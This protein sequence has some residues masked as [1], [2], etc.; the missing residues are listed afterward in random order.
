METIV[1]RKIPRLHH[2]TDNVICFIASLPLP[3][4]RGPFMDCCS[5]AINPQ[6]I[7]WQHIQTMINTRRKIEDDPNSLGRM[8]VTS[9]CCSKATTLKPKLR[10]SKRFRFNVQMSGIGNIGR[11]ML[12]NP[13]PPSFA[14][15]LPFPMKG[16]SSMR[17][18]GRPG[19]TWDC[20]NPYHAP[21]SAVTGCR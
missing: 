20:L 21:V 13:M 2:Y 1:N 6:D 19:M 3:L 10:K 17:A 4:V 9:Y 15:L 12:S 16:C 8:P 11:G 18:E 5:N 14:V 7:L